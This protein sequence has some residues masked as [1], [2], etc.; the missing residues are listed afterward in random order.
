[1]DVAFVVD[2]L[3]GDDDSLALW[4]VSR[5]LACRGHTVSLVDLSRDERWVEIDG[6]VVL[7]V[8]T[9]STG[10]DALD[11]TASTL[12]QLL[13]KEVPADVVVVGPTSAAAGV[14]AR[15]GQGD[16]DAR[17]TVVLDT[18]PD[19][20]PV[21][22]SAYPDR[23]APRAGE[24]LVIAAVGAPALS[25][26]A[27]IDVDGLLTSWKGEV[28]WVHGGSADRW[29]AVLARACAVRQVTPVALWDAWSSRSSDVMAAVAGAVGCLVLAR[30]ACAVVPYANVAGVP[31]GTVWPLDGVAQDR[32]AVAAESAAAI[33]HLERRLG[34]ATRR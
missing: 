27:G 16:D 21:C 22:S 28:T 25:D 14:L 11:D 12:G 10:N 32:A 30:A 3:R 26:P 2:A 20:L 9:T 24:T 19:V 15:L 17:P 4:E 7:G 6:V 31:V 13:R 34:E 1:M 23:T 18:G 8:P 33:D 5:S 29:S